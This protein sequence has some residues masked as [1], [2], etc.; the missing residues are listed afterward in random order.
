MIPNGHNRKLKPV[1]LVIGVAL[2]LGVFTTLLHSKRLGIEYLEEGNQRYRLNA[3]MD[4]KAGSPWQY[5]VLSA[6]AIA[7]TMALFKKMNLPYY[8]LSTF[9]LFRAIS[10]ISIF[11]IAWLYYRKLGLTSINALIGMCLIAWGISY[12]NYDS[13]LQ[14]STY[15]DILFYLLGG[16]CIVYRK[17]LWIIPIVLLAA[18][19]RESSGLIMLM[20]F[21]AFIRKD[22]INAQ[23][24]ILTIFSVCLV[25]YFTIYFSLRFLYPPQSM[26]LPYGHQLGID[27]MMYNLTRSVTWERVALTLGFFIP[28]LAIAGYRKW[29]DPLKTFFWV[30]VPL[31]FI[32][33][34]F[35][36]VMAES[37]LLLVP[38]VMVF[39]P[40]LMFFAQQPAQSQTKNL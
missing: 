7:G 11:L 25:I 4:Q 28:I 8:A 1:M 3:I 23:I 10:D 16:L 26:L 12:A 15:F 17:P 32:I 27:M 13:D 39:I 29:P 34:L 33:H 22:K 35:A 30:I 9:V 37:R 38:Q 6:Y 31:W 24:R 40:G 5:R 18:L 14:F 20:F 2:L 19:N 36:A 21:F